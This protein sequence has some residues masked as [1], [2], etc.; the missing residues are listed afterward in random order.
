M[1]RNGFTIDQ[2]FDLH[3]KADYEPFIDITAQ[4]VNDSIIRMEKI[5][6]NLKF[7]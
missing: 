1:S 3:H 5:F 6:N 4:E 7:D 2:L